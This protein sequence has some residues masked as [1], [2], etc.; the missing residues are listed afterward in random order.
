[1]NLNSW[2]EDELLLVTGKDIHYFPIS[3]STLSCS[4]RQNCCL[5]FPIEFNYVNMVKVCEKITIIDD[6][7][8]ALLRS[9]ERPDLLPQNQFL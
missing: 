3:Y 7:K 6:S 9:D 1:M 5:W 8:P 4:Y 2:D